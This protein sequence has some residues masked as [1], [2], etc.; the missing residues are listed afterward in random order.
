MAND[1]RDA[2][3][4]VIGG[5]HALLRARA[6]DP[7]PPVL[8]GEDDQR[9]VEQ[10]VLAK[11]VE[12]ASDIPVQRGYRRIV[13]GVVLPFI[14]FEEALGRIVGFVRRIVGLIEK[15]RFVAMPLDEANALIG[16]H[17]GTEAR[18]VR[19]ADPVQQQRVETLP[20]VEESG[21]GRTEVPFADVSGGVAGSVEEVR[22]VVP[23]LEAAVAERIG[24]DVL[25][26]GI[27]RAGV[28]LVDV[29][30]KPMQMRVG[31]REDRRAAGTAKGLRYV[32]GVKP[33]ARFSEVIEVGRMAFAQAVATDS[34]AAAFVKEK[35]DDVGG[36]LHAVLLRQAGCCRDGECRVLR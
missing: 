3:G 27:R 4:L 19:L 26:R 13:I 14:G 36:R 32:G 21:V 23:Q 17:V 1:Q 9:L 33:R 8:G 31:P 11:R 20:V 12:D 34:V 35:K 16:M 6:I 5:T 24:D 22:E 18:L 29:L 2:R 7:G 30:P 15:E 25:I 10:V 28:R